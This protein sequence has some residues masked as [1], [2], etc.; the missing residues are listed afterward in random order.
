MT[1]IVPRR[2][3]GPSGSTVPALALGSFHTWERAVFEEA[4]ELLRHAAAAG[5][6]MFDVAVY[7]HDFMGP[8]AAAHDS[9]TDLILARALQ[10]AGIRRE[11]Y[12]L[13]AKAWF[14]PTQSIPLAQQLD[15][16]LVR[17]GAEHA[18]HLIVESIDNPASFDLGAVVAEIGDIL[19]AGT[20]RHWAVNNWSAAQVD[21][22]F[23]ACAR[24][25]VAP[26]QY[27]QMKYGLAHRTVVEGAPFQ[28]LC[29]RTGFSVQA[30]RALAGGLLLG[31]GRARRPG[32][33]LDWLDERAVALAARLREV[34]EGF[35]ATPAQFALA[36][37][38][39]DPHTANVLVGVRT[40]AQF[41]E[42]LG[43][44]DLLQR[45]DHAALRAAADEFWIDRG[46]ID[47]TSGGG[48][49]SE[50]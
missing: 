36:Y 37:P 22:A 19:R 13:A 7:R 44:F 25:G 32:Q 40:P 30:S 6:L 47:P 35:G 41:D 43:A 46:R 49:G 42:L 23:T 9:P 14:P 5:A 10:V 26:P 4:V 24:L 34:A 1:T 29:A 16:L 33:M 48:P 45:A 20:A 2:A 3:C 17:H 27:G 50:R 8:G 11:Q 21:A 38:L 31:T 15:E 12:L 18:D 39:L 28:E